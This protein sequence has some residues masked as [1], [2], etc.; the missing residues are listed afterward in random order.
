MTTYGWRPSARRS[1]SDAQ[2]VGEAIEALGDELG[3]VSTDAIVTAARAAHSVLHPQF[4]WDD[5]RAAESFRHDQARKLVRDLVVVNVDRHGEVHDGVQAFVNI[6]VGEGRQGYIAV[7]TVTTDRVMMRQTLQVALDEFNS[8]RRRHRELVGL[9]NVNGALDE[10]ARKI[11][12]AI[13]GLEPEPDDEPEPPPTV[14]VARQP[15][16]AGKAWPG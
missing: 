1:G 11:A 16:S 8:W 15:S 2:D 12:E 4:E 13:L 14:R 5:E 6:V 10:L 9:A 3:L 7:A